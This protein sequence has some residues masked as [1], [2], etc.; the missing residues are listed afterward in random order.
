MASL[1]CCCWLNWASTHTHAAQINHLAEGVWIETSID[2]SAG[3]AHATTIETIHFT[4]LD[5]I[6]VLQ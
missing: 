3:A 4:C 6:G 5:L 1:R 2:R